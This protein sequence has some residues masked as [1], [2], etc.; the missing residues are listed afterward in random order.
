MQVMRDKDFD[1]L[2]KDQFDH[3]EIQPSRNLWDDISKELVP[4]KEKNRSLYWSVAATILIGCAIGLL[5]PKAEKIRLHGAAIAE[6]EQPRGGHRQ[7]FTPEQVTPRSEKSTPLILAPKLELEN[8]T[9]INNLATLQPN[10]ADAH[11][12]VKRSELPPVKEIEIKAN[13]Q[14]SDIVVANIDSPAIPETVDQLAAVKEG[15]KGI[16][17]MGD[18]INFVVN[19]LDKREKKIIQFKTD[20]DDNSSLVAINI[21]ILKFNPKKDRNN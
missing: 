13:V 14:F 20:D 1:Q 12:I 15:G 2:F 21:G 17:N 6:V 18:I 19:K 7:A 8:E 10:E 11:P 16:R 4:Q 5:Y 3:A 9:P